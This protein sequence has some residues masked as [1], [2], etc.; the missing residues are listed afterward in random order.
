MSSIV[1]IS[2][3]PSDLFCVACLEDYGRALEAGSATWQQCGVCSSPNVVSVD[4]SESE[5]DAADL[6]AERDSEEPTSS[7]DSEGSTSSSD[8]EVST[9]EAQT[10][11]LIR[12][13][14]GDSA[15]VQYRSLSEWRK[16]SAGSR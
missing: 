12:V 16:K 15:S 2:Q 6:A 10:S 13:V 9:V 5:N 7:S 4:L 3:W 8:S 14:V 11:Q 1:V